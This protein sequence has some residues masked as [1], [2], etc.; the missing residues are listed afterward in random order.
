MSTRTT[1]AIPSRKARENLIRLLFKAQDPLTVTGKPAS[2]TQAH[3]LRSQEREAASASITGRR[4][5]YSQ[6]RV[7]Y[8]EKVHAMHPD[9]VGAIHNDGLP[10]KDMHL[11]FIELKNAWEEYHASVR[12]AQRRCDDNSSRNKYKTSEGNDWEEEENFTMFGVGCSFA[13]SQEERDLRFEITEQACRGW[14]PSGS[15]TDPQSDNQKNNSSLSQKSSVHQLRLS[16]ND[17]FVPDERPMTKVEGSR[18]HLVQNADKFIRK[19]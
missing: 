6:L 5:S 7:A 8:L 10:S 4:H 13:D 1:S 19:R 9:K 15:I 18:K 11:Q 2:I 17:M 3:R 16:D 14:F 12:I